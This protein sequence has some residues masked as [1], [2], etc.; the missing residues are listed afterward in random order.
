MIIVNRAALLCGL[1]ATVACWPA[2]EEAS[3]AASA[4]AP[5]APSFESDLASI[6]AVA[7]DRFEAIRS[8]RTPAA[9]ADAYVR[10]VARDAVWMPPHA[11]FVSGRDAIRDW[12]EEFFSNW[13]I[14]IAAS[15]DVTTMISGDLAV[16]RW[17]SMGTFVS[18]G[19]GE[20]VPFHQK[21]VEVFSRLDD[22]HWQISLRMWS[23]NNDQPDI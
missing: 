2:A 17:V 21:F 1:L 7:F 6:E 9:Q 13:V 3:R 14:E 16:R 23:S 12:A 20:A 8:A 4:Q 15:T 18:R 10:G 22:D 19:G 5:R 11:S